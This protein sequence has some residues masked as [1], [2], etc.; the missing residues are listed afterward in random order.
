MRYGKICVINCTFCNFEKKER[1]SPVVA[2]LFNAGLLKASPV[3]NGTQGSLWLE[4]EGCSLSTF[5][6]HIAYFL[7]RLSSVCSQSCLHLFLTPKSTFLALLSQAKKSAFCHLHRKTKM[8]DTTEVA[9]CILGS[10]KRVNST[11]Q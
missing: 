8:A 3:S 1:M 2:F 9:N 6:A 11:V 10:N 4:A 5:P 7:F